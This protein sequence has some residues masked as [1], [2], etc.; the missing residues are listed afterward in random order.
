MTILNA[1]NLRIDRLPDWKQHFFQLQ[2]FNFYK[3]VLDDSLIQKTADDGALY[4]YLK[5]TYE[6]ERTIEAA[7]S[8]LANR[9]NIQ[10]RLAITPAKFKASLKDSDSPLEENCQREYD[11]ILDNQANICMKIFTKPLCVISG[12]AGTGKTTV[13]R[14]ILKN[15]KRV[16]GM[17]TS[18]LLL[19]ITVNTIIIDECSVRP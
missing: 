16:H 14:A 6:D 8:R 19:A 11:K 12:N 5:E 4:L 1:V 15:I 17:G 13:I 2:N 7:L 18:F 10:L 9:N 3:A